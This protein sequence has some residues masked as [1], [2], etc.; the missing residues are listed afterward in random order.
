MSYFADSKI[1]LSTASTSTSACFLSDTSFLHNCTCSVA[2][3]VPRP[4]Q[5]CLAHSLQQCQQ[6][7]CGG[8]R[9]C[10]LSSK[11]WFYVVDNAVPGTETK[12]YTKALYRPYNH[13]SR[14]QKASTCIQQE[15][16]VRSVLIVHI[17][18]VVSQ[19]AEA[20]YGVHTID[21]KKPRPGILSLRVYTQATG[22][23]GANTTIFSNAISAVKR[24]QQATK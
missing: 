8:T 19:A 6:M 7:A 10:R 12:L 9:P 22:E 21:P 23:S 4:A 5:D 17:P 3:N 20:D 11:M 18:W 15:M 1:K 13:F 24:C 2:P 16:I 14:K